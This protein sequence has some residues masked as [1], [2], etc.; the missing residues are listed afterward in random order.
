MPCPELLIKNVGQR[1]SG[2]TRTSRID[3]PTYTLYS[4]AVPL[5]YWGFNRARSGYS[6]VIA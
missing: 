5:R 1:H 6:L 4:H 3:V 2:G